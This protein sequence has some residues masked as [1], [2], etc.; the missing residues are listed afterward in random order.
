MKAYGFEAILACGTACQDQSKL[1]FGFSRKKNT[2]FVIISGGLA[3]FKTDY[4]AFL[5][6]NIIGEGSV[7]LMEFC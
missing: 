5:V 6:K 2:D 3:Q 7:R 4:I 1:V